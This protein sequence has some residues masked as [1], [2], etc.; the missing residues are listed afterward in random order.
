MT[1]R[2]KQARTELIH[3]MTR[4]NFSLDTELDRRLRDQAAATR[5]PLSWVIV[6]L[7]ADGYALR[8]QAPGREEVA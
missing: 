8:G 2:L 3:R 6:D 4:M 5:T 1:R 7:I